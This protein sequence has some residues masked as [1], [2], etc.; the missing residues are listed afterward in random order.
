MGKTRGMTPDARL[1]RAHN[2]GVLM[3]R[4]DTYEPEV[5]RLD[6]K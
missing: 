4:M 2:F 5:H 1:G 3:T 6:F